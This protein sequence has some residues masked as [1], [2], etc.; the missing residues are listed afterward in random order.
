L[1]KK[2]NVFFFLQFILFTFALTNNLLYGN[3]TEKSITFTVSALHASGWHY[4]QAGYS[5]LAVEGTPAA[6]LNKEDVVARLIAD[7]CPDGDNPTAPPLSELT[8]HIPV[9]AVTAKMPGKDRLKSITTHGLRFF[10]L[11]A[12]RIRVKTLTLHHASYEA[13]GVKGVKKRTTVLLPPCSVR[14]GTVHLRA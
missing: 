8:C 7:V 14:A 13:D 1:A 3:H 4:R 5:A 11:S 2:D 10:L 9:M 12:L 6:A